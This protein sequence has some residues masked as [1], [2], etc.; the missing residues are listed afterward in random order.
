MDTLISAVLHQEQ[1]AKNSQAQAQAR[2]QPLAQAQESTSSRSSLYSGERTD[3]KEDPMEPPSARGRPG[4]PPVKGSPPGNENKHYTHSPYVG[5]A[6]GHPPHPSPHLYPSSAEYHANMAAYAATRSSHS[7]TGSTGTYTPQQSPEIAAAQ[8]AAASHGLAYYHGKPHHPGHPPYHG[9]YPT[10]SPSPTVYTPS[11]AASEPAYPQ[12][13]PP[14]MSSL[15]LPPPKLNRDP[16]AVSSEDDKSPALASHSESAKGKATGVRRASTASAG[17][18]RRQRAQPDAAAIALAIERTKRA[19]IAS[20]QKRRATIRKGFARIQALVPGCHEEGISKASILNKAGDYIEELR[21]QLKME[22]GSG[23]AAPKPTNTSTASTATTT[24]TTPPLL[25]DALQKQTKVTDD[26]REKLNAA[27][28]IIDRLNSDRRGLNRE[29][30]D[31]KT[32]VKRT[33]RS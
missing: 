6:E 11:H 12:G 17:G 19:H 25:D 23:E 16:Q 30:S 5:P 10:Y 21:S 4:Q 8:A 20:E 14:S 33:L 15:V 32:E 24:S 31:L 29:I 27:M 26:L 22:G 28:N 2:A 7:I 9:H 1:E 3:T 13:G 18:R